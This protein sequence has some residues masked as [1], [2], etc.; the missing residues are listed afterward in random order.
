MFDVAF[1]VKYLHNLLLIIGN[2][3][4]FTHTNDLLIMI[5]STTLHYHILHGIRSQ[6]DSIAL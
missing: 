2:M 1:I 3:F 4:E 5:S 6:N